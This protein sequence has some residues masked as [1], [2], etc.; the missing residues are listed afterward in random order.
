[1]LGRGLSVKDQVRLGAAEH[2][3]AAQATALQYLAARPRTAHEVRQKL[4][5]SGVAD[6]VAEQVIA[7]LQARGALADVPYTPA[8]LTPR[9]AS[10]GYGPQRLRQELQQRGIGRALVEEAVQQ[11]LAAGDVLAVA[12]AQAEQRWARLAREND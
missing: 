11:D 7:R 6:Q 1:G 5:R 2:L 12:R 8:Y 3:L 10:R 4:R 9:R